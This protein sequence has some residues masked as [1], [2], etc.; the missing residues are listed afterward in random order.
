MNN[1]SQI[2]QLCA[3]CNLGRPA[4][5]PQP[6]SGGLLHRMWQLTTTQ[7]TYAIKQ[8]N[9]AIMGRPHIHDLYRMSERI[10]AA[11]AE[12]TI[13]AVAALNCNG[14]PLQQID[15]NSYLVYQWVDGTILSRQPAD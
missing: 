1:T 14:D 7:G 2:A 8:L 4:T 13:P 10:A 5:D 15:D 9:P 11:M 6:V 3:A 12:N